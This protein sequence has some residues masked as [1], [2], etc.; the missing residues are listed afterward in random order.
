MGEALRQAQLDLTARKVLGIPINTMFMT[1]SLE[2]TNLS[3][4]VSELKTEIVKLKD[5]LRLYGDWIPNEQPRVV[6]IL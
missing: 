2:N 6:H 4:Q 1:F 3:R 5:R